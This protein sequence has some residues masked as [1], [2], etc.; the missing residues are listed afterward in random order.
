MKL[1]KEFPIDIVIPV[2]NEGEFEDDEIWGK[3]WAEQC[4]NN[5]L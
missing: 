5:L 2:F 4:I 3:K 1:N